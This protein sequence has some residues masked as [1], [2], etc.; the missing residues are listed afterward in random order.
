MISHH[1]KVI[2][3][4]TI[5]FAPDGRLQLDLPPELCRFPIRGR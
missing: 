4:E 2:A 3:N 1:S 5:R